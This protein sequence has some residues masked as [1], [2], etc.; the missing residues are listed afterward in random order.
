MLYDVFKRQEEFMEL[1][2]VNDKLPEWPVDLT[3]KPGQ[4]LIKET[5]F[6]LSDELHEAMATLKNKQH[7][8]TDDRT[9]DFAHYKEELG[10]AFAFFIEI[11]ILSGINA[12]DLYEEYC[13]KN[14]A[15]KER[16]ARGY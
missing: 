12:D 16:L 2:R 14:K 7:R 15:V 3:I 9:L 6:N 10:D 1:L 4:R 5:A 8:L 13:H 11:C